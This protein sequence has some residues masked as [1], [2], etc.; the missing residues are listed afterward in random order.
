MR[1]VGSLL[2]TSSPRLFHDFYGKAGSMKALH[3]GDSL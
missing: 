1:G 3:Q 2:R